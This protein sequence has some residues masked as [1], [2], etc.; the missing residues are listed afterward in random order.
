MRYVFWLLLLVVVP[1]VLF[2]STFLG[3]KTP[4]ENVAMG[5]KKPLDSD[6][7]PGLPDSIHVRAWRDDLDSACYHIEHTTYPFT[8]AGMDTCKAHGGDTTYVLRDQV[9]DFGGAAGSCLSI[10]VTLYTGGI[11]TQTIGHVQVVTTNFNTTLANITTMA[12]G[13]NVSSVNADAI[14]AGDFATGAIDD[15]AIADAATEI[16]AD[17]SALALQTE[18]ANIDGWNPATTGI[19]VASLGANVI[20]DAA[21]ADAATEI[22]ADVSALALQ[23]EVV[24]IDGWNPATLNDLTAAEV[25][26]EAEDALEALL[27]FD[28]DADLDSLDFGELFSV[29]LPSMQQIDSLRWAAGEFENAASRYST[30]S[31]KD[32]L[33]FYIDATAIGFRLYYH[34]GGSPG[35]N[36]DSTRYFVAP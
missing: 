9:Q 8:T 6:G 25:Q 17:I 24:N 1:S 26:A 33:W 22:K 14:Q 2:S 32:T 19:I 29:Y 11:G 27:D 23:S 36:P 10:D 31:D 3:F 30:T 15:D 18:V 20:T 28:N 21:I 12:T 13:V 35:G 16:K 4:A 34:V 5:L 7:L